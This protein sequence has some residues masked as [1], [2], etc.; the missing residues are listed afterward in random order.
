MQ[1]LVG[2]NVATSNGVLLLKG[3]LFENANFYGLHEALGANIIAIDFAG[4]TKA[5]WNGLLKLND[6]LSA[7][8]AKTSSRIEIRNVPFSVYK[9]FRMLPGFESSYYVTSSEL[10]KIIESQVSLT[11]FSNTDLMIDHEADREEAFFSKSRGKDLL[12]R[13][14]FFRGFFELSKEQRSYFLFADFILDYLL[15]S[16]AIFAVSADLAEGLGV[17][18][19]RSYCEAQ[20]M[21]ERSKQA[22]DLMG[23]PLKAGLSESLDSATK[24][25]DTLIEAYSSKISSV[26]T[27]IRL[28]IEAIAV[29]VQ[30]LAQSYGEPSLS[31]LNRV[32]ECVHT[33][34]SITSVA[35]DL[36]TTAGE[37]FGFAE[38]VEHGLK[39]I[40]HL[41]GKDL[42]AEQMQTLV[43]IYDISDPMADEKDYLI[44]N[45]ADMYSRSKKEVEGLSTTIQGCDLIRQIMEHRIKEA[46]V[47]ESYIGGFGN[48]LMSA[49]ISEQFRGEL[50]QTIKRKMVTDQ[51]KYAFGYFIADYAAEAPPSAQPG[52]ILLF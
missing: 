14:L 18:I 28:Q 40:K 2:F 36:G 23:L 35:E 16:E 15:Y 31:L 7:K 50:I 32:V 38:V 22:F 52:E 43:D 1:E 13:K 27:Q 49:A 51:E 37:L 8:A 12:G 11:N 20:R 48:D 34:K 45:I 47:L 33:S 41:E 19:K 3:I 25:F 39:F 10:P 26:A 44:E 24:D 29:E 21:T 4:L 9:F 6:I 30:L 17:T 42:T 46:D 5:S